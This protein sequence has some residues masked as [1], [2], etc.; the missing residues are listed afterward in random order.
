MMV[1]WW[2]Q[3]ASLREPEKGRWA[4]GLVSI[5]HLACSHLAI[6]ASQFADKQT[7]R[8]QCIRACVAAFLKGSRLTC[9]VWQSR[10]GCGE[11]PTLAPCQTVHGAALC[12]AGG[13]MADDEKS[14]KQAEDNINIWKIKKLIKSLEAARGW[15]SAPP[16]P[17][18]S[19]CVCPVRRLVA[20]AQSAAPDA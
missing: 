13:S 20:T 3:L 10:Q 15:A 6:W 19:A 4:R 14:N 16:P 17:A 5:S 7:I 2:P 1:G 18:C 11:V 12:G 9:H 8:L